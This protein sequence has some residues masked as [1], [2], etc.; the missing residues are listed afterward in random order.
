MKVRQ[1]L[2]VSAKPIL[3]EIR[4]IADSDLSFEDR[5]DATEKF[6]ELRNLS[7]K[8]FQVFAECPF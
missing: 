3:I 5:S 8:S 4:H 1:Y 7:F 2:N 6:D